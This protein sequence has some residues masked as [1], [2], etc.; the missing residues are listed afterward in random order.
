M[1]SRARNGRGG[2]G[3]GP[4][5]A[6][7]RAGGRAL[8]H[9]DDDEED[10]E[11]AEHGQGRRG[12]GG[13]H[14]A[15]VLH[16]AHHP[17]HL[18]H[19]GRPHQPQQVPRRRPRGAAEGGRGRGGGDGGDVQQAAWREGGVGEFT[20][21]GLRELGRRRWLQTLRNGLIRGVGALVTAP[22]RERRRRNARD[23]RDEPGARR[24]G[25]GAPTS[26]R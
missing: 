14:G 23:D 13:D 9:A 6:G 1:R 8:T 18:H 20:R 4:G 24:A 22:V 26:S 16:P 19:P 12:D 17:D 25:P 21:A 11:G 3:A 15:Q 10:A 2:R 5:R 7:G